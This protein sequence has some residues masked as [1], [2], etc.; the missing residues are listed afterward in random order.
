VQDDKNETVLETMVSRDIAKII[1]CLSYVFIYPKTGGLQKM[2]NA[3]VEADE[4]FAKKA[5]NTAKI[6]LWIAVI[7]IGLVMLVTGSTSGSSVQIDDV[8]NISCTTMKSGNCYYFSEAVVCNSYATLIEKELNSAGN[9][10]SASYEDY[11]II[12]FTDKDGVLVY[13][14]LTVE[15]DSELGQ[16]CEAYINDDT[17]KIGDLI[18]S[19]CYVGR[20]EKNSEALEYFNEVY[21]IYNMLLPGRRL[22]WTFEY[23]GAQTMEEYC[24]NQAGSGMAR[25]IF[26]VLL[27]I[28]GGI[29]AVVLLRKRKNL[30]PGG[31]V[32]RLQKYAAQ[33]LPADLNE[34]SSYRE[35][36]EMLRTTFPLTEDNIPFAKKVFEAGNLGNMTMQQ[37]YVR[38]SRSVESWCGS[39]KEKEIRKSMETLF[40]QQLLKT[41]IAL[42]FFAV[43]LDSEQRGSI[44]K[45]HQLIAGNLYNRGFEI[46]EM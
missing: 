28:V 22:D 32:L 21:E 1:F 30:V 43:A 11:Y 18:I 24:S 5:G 44:M 15:R 9:V 39:F 23:N 46:P 34:L 3:V 42:T 45:Y 13:T 17:L 41:F 40:P 2:N 27:M 14:G 38:L 37:F 25:S 31:Y 4:L 33:F 7:V 16:K 35:I 29:G 6:V 12:C 8:T 20:I 26:G 19:G 10:T 36:F